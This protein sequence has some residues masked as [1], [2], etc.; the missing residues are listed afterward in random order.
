LA[1]AAVA[2]RWLAARRE[3]ALDLRECVPLPSWKG[4]PGWEFT[5]LGE[6]FDLE[7]FARPADEPAEPSFER[8][9]GAPD[10]AVELVQVG[11]VAGDAPELPDGVIVAP[12]DVAAER[13]PEIVERHLGS[14]VELDSGDRFVVENEAAWEGGALVHVPAGVV[15]EHPIVLTQALVGERTGLHRR[16]LVVLEEAAE[17]EVWDQALSHLDDEAALLNT[18]VELVVGQGA[19]LRYVAGQELNERSWVFGNQRAE[20]QRDGMLDWV[21]L[22]FGGGTGHIRMET[23]LAG[24]GAGARVTGAYATHGRQHLDFDTT[25]EH[26]APD[27]NSDLAFRGVLQ[28]RSNAVWRGMIRVDPGAQRTDAFQ[29]SRNLLLS[30]RAHADAIPGLEIQADDV[31]CTHAAAIAQVDRDQLYYLMARGLPREQAT[32]LI[33]DGFMQELVERFPEG[34]VHDALS[35]ALE[36]RLETVLGS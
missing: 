36:Q 7:A 15:V 28:G 20:V 30:K 5:D 21:A 23:R 19:R 10:G 22:G 35:T 17:A 3:R 16:T 14:L 4:R 27:T 8:V 26:A 34:A 24:R 9:L 18:V 31:R 33:I 29:E 25:Q 6:G 32:R 12:L 1:S 2:P 11:S 13:H